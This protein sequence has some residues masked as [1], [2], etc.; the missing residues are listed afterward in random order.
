MAGHTQIPPDEGQIMISK[1]TI[2]VLGLALLGSASLQPQVRQRLAVSPASGRNNDTAMV[3]VCAGP[4]ALE[5]FS[6]ESGPVL[7]SFGKATCDGAYGISLHFRPS[8]QGTPKN[9]PVRTR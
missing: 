3:T 8:P 2:V 4:M 6:R 5:L 7:V 9:L 1:L